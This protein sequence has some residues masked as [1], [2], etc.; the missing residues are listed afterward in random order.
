M[1]VDYVLGDVVVV[2]VVGWES[3]VGD[4]VVVCDDWLDRGWVCNKMW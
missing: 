3:K 1:V 4:N 2:L